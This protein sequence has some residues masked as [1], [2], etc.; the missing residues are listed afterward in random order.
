MFIEHLKSEQ[1]PPIIGVVFL[2]SVRL[3]ITSADVLQDIYI[4]K[5]AF[6]TKEPRASWTFY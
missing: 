3:T 5:N 6:T 2:G 4:N 1:L